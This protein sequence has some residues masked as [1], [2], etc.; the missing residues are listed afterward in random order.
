MQDRHLC[1]P[2]LFKFW[3]RHCRLG[4]MWPEGWTQLV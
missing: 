3:N 1:C 4:R 2:S